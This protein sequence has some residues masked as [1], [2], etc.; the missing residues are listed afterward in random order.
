MAIS[1]ITPHF[2]NFEG[3]KQIYDCLV[4]QSAN[5]WEW[6]IVDD[7]S[8]PLVKASIV[9]Y[10]KQNSNSNI[11]LV[12]TDKKTTA[13]VCRNIGINL[14]SYKYLVFLDS[15]DLISDDFVSNRLIEVEDFVV[16]KNFNLLDEYG[17]SRPAPSANANYLDH[18]LQAK[19]IWQTSCVLWNKA[20]LK[21]IGKFNTELNRLQ[22]VELFIRALLNSKSYKVIDNKVDFY[23]RVAPIDIKKKPVHL[24][25]GAVDFLI[26]YMHVHYQ[27][28]KRQRSLVTGYYFLCIRYFG[29]SNNKGDLFYLQNSLSL[30]YTKKYMSFLSYMRASSFLKLYKYHLIS[31]DMFIRLN[32]YFY[33]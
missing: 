20:F 19:F 27:L 32:R 25:C 21:S 8:E 6:I 30:F 1:I 3:I 24:I 18:F 23:Y 17:N 2:N 26:T 7:F 4:K 15:D 31:R 29:K 13:S 22:D 5:D 9:E 14:A 11:E 28:D 12:F 16:F 33:K 10:F